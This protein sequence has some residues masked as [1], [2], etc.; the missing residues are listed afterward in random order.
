MQTMSPTPRR[1]I[2]SV[3]E[4]QRALLGL[5][6]WI[7]SFALVAVVLVTLGGALWANLTLEPMRAAISLRMSH[8]CGTIVAWPAPRLPST[9]DL[10]TLATVWRA[11]DCFMHG[12]TH[13]QAVSLKY[14]WGGMDFSFTDTFVVEPTEGRLAGCALADISQGEVVG[15]P[16][17]PSTHRCTGVVRLADGLHILG[18][19]TVISVPTDTPPPG[20]PQAT[21]ILG[22]SVF[23]FDK[24]FGATNCCFENGWTYQ[25]PY[26]QIWTRIDMEQTDFGAPTKNMDESSL[27]RV[28]GILNAGVGGYGA[29]WTMAQA[30]AI[31]ESFLPPDAKYQTSAY[32]ASGATVIGIALYYTS[33]SLANTLP[34]RDFTHTDTHGNNRLA[35]LGA[36]YVFYGYGKY[37]FND[38]ASTTVDQ[39]RVGTNEWSTRGGL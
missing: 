22:G 33:A 2:R 39:C 34:P 7:R 38:P 13:C 28:I 16:H 29:G 10:A 12:Y 18:C 4:L 27:A 35:S 20:I 26:G 37:S 21:A 23:A 14:E 1:G 36:F 30:K 6:L 15:V 11:E 19:D 9:T 24:R 17:G 25:G 3:R 8:S 5:P 31:C 32:V